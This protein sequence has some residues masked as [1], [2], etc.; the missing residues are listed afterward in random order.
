[1][2]IYLLA[3][4]PRREE[5]KVFSFLQKP[6][7]RKWNNTK[8]LFFSIQT[9]FMNLWK[10]RGERNQGRKTKEGVTR[11]VAF[12][13][14]L[15]GWVEFPWQRWWM[16]K[17]NNLLLPWCQLVNSISLR[18]SIFLYEMRV[19]GYGRF[20]PTSYLVL[21]CNTDF[22]WTLHNTMFAWILTKI[23]PT[24]LFY[25]PFCVSPFPPIYP[26]WVNNDHS[27]LKYIGQPLPWL[28]C[29]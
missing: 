6:G 17:E 22:S 27:L 25:A 13:L 7:Q 24:H 29:K 18:S 11:E 10:F 20:P 21:V 23:F 26:L 1:M 15:E 2:L 28:C 14:N 9:E 3:K 16:G 5:G 4:E 12:E 19:R 8:L